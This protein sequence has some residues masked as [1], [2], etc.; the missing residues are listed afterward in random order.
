LKK[1]PRALSLGVAEIKTGAG[2]TILI[3]PEGV[4]PGAWNHV[5]EAPMRNE[6]VRR[7]SSEK[8][9]LGLPRMF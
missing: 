4:D 8:A 9:Q 6:A 7:H 2:E 5:A 1:G 3:L